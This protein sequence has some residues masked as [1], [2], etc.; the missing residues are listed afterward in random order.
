MMFCKTFLKSDLFLTQLF[1]LDAFIKIDTDMLKNEPPKWWA[2]CKPAP[3]W[4]QPNSIAIC[5]KCQMFCLSM[6]YNT[7]TMYW[8]MDPCK[9]QNGT[10]LCFG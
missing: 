6:P 9:M 5:V 4:W 2:I 1:P 8:L 7:I 3:N 10:S